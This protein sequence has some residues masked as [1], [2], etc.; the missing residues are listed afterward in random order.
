MFRELDVESKTSKSL[1]GPLLEKVMKDMARRDTE[2][3]QVVF[4]PVARQEKPTLT[5]GIQAPRMETLPY[6]LLEPVKPVPLPYRPSGPVKMLPLAMPKETEEEPL[7]GGFGIQSRGGGFGGSFGG[8]QIEGGGRQESKPVMLPLAQAARDA[9]PYGGLPKL[10]FTSL[11]ERS[12]QET[13]RLLPTPGRADAGRGS[14]ATSYDMQVEL[15]KLYRQAAAFRTAQSD[16][17][18]L[19]GDPG[20]DA[21]LERTE[22]EIAVLEEKRKR[23]QEATNQYLTETIDSYGAKPEK[24]TPGNMAQ[25]MKRIE[26]LSKLNIWTDD[27]RREAKEI[28]NVMT[29][30][31][32]LWQN[33]MY[34]LTKNTK[35]QGNYNQLMGDEAVKSGNF[36]DFIRYNEIFADLSNKVHVKSSSAVSGL[37]QGTGALS[38]AEAITRGAAKA[39]GDEKI[40]RAFE[41]QIGKIKEISQYGRE[42]APLAHGIGSVVGNA[43]LL[44]NAASVIGAIPGVATL[45]LLGQGALTAGGAMAVNTAIQEAGDYASDRINGQQYLGDIGTSALM[46]GAG[47]LASAG[48]GVF[49][50]KALY[51]LGIQNSVP[52]IILRDGLSG[53][54]FSAGSMGARYALDENYRPTPEEAAK[55]AA[56]GFFFGAVT[57]LLKSSGMT[58]EGKAR[59]SETV[60][61]MKRDYGTIL[62]DSGGS[63]TLD[64]LDDLVAKSAE[65]R[66][67]LR[68]TQFA[69]QQDTVSG[70]M[71]LLDMLD[72]AV[73][74]ARVSMGTGTIGRRGSVRALVPGGGGAAPGLPPSLPTPYP[75]LGGAGTQCMPMLPSPAAVRDDWEVALEE[76]VEEWKGLGIRGSENVD[77]SGES[78]II[79][80]KGTR[81]TDGWF[82]LP[83]PAAEG[84]VSVEGAGETTLADWADNTKE[85][86]KTSPIKI[87]EGA[88]IKSGTKASGYD[89]ISYKWTDSGYNYEARWHTKTPGAPTGQGNTWVVSRVTQGAPTGRRRV[90]HIMVGNT[91]VTRAAWQDA[92]K[93]YQNGTMTAAQ[94]AMLKAGHWLA[95]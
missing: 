95:P 35:Y 81:E 48:A 64:A 20:T 42:N 61:Q 76:A 75:I 60:E 40:E 23:Q 30:Y 91:W 71:E 28:L 87:P 66:N 29:G 9:M 70:V 6:R 92:I 62:A 14:F 22:R 17:L 2:K 69:G 74:Q 86:A 58:R 54:A 55:D 52:A 41:D 94:E 68:T 13:P 57:S 25:N 46:G 56:V 72:D 80:N 78:G 83:D 39:I 10:Q 37:M 16:L 36:S 31:G 21:Q 50:T 82:T 8:R 3:P 26:A 19:G 15:N 12:A 4:L 89:Q 44:G 7:R 47:G 34:G 33:F 51:G 45:P 49:G 73:E 5:K 18:T 88:T 77:I 53:A 79:F 24:Y 32:G 59:M 63:V 84:S 1:A 85:L 65:V 38:I 11:A 27:Q 67:T 93:A 43:A 90:I